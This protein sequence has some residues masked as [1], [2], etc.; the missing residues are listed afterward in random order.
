M[1]SPM[2][3]HDCTQTAA[4]TAMSVSSRPLRPVIFMRLVGNVYRRVFQL[5]FEFEQK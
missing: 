5:P 4:R 1:D 3:N 2:P